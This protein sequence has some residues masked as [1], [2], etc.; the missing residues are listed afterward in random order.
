MLPIEPGT[1]N[2]TFRATRAN[3]WKIDSTQ[4]LYLEERVNVQLGTYDF[5]AERAVVWVERI[6]S[7]KGVITQIAVW[8]PQTSEP[9][10]AAGLGASGS[11][12]L[13]TASTLGDTTL[14]AVLVTPNAPSG[15]STVRSGEQRM[16]EY[17]RGLAERPPLLSLLPDVRRPPPPPPPEPLVVG[18][19]VL[20]KPVAKP[21]GVV[22]VPPGTV[23]LADTPA[24]GVQPPTS[25]EAPTSVAAETRAPIIAPKSLVAFVA[26]K[27]QI[28]TKADTVTLT[29]GVTLDVLPRSP[30]SN[31]RMMQM[32]AERAV[33]FLKPGTTEGLKGVAGEQLTAESVLGVYLEGDISVTDFDYTVRAKRAYYD[34]AK[35]RA[36]LVEGVLR[37]IDRS[38]LPLV[39][40]AAEL[41]QYSQDQWRGEKLVVSTSEFF[42]PHLSVGVERATI[43]R[44]LNDEGK[45]ESYVQGEDVTFRASRTPFFWLPGFEGTGKDIPLRGIG[46]G[47]AGDYGTRITTRWDLLGLLGAENDRH[48]DMTLYS[49]AWINWGA[50]AGVKGK[51]L[52]FKFDAFGLW[53]F[54]NIERTSAGVNVISPNEFR[55]I[56][57]MQRTFDF[58]SDT[59]LQLQANYVSDESFMQIFRQPEFTTQFQ[60]ETSAY[61]VSSGEHSE[62]SLLLNYPTNNVITNGS[63]LAARPYQVAKY[64]EAAYKRWGDSLFGDTVTWTQEYSAN[65][66]AIRFGK[67]SETTTGILSNTLNLE[68]QVLPSGLTF[69]RDTTIKQLYQGSGYADDTYTRLYTRQEL[70]MPLGSGGVHFT[71]FTS[72]A[73]SG[74]VNGNPGT[75]NPAADRLRGLLTFG[76]RASADIMANYDSV[77]MPFL[78]VHRLRH[79][80]TPYANGWY[81]YDSAPEDAYAIFDQD[82]EGATGGAVVQGGVRQRFQTMRGGA[83]NWRSVDWLV[84]DLGAT[85]NDGADTFARDYTSGAHYRQSPFPQFFVWRPELSQ[86]GRTAYGSFKWA[87]SST[88]SFNGNLTY[89]LDSDLPAL[90]QGPFGLSNA[91]RGM[92]G[93]QMQHSPD[94]STFIEYR[95]I[96]NNSPEAIYISDQLLA[97]GINYRVSRTYELGFTPTYDLLENNFRSFNVSVKRELPDFSLVGTFGYDV[98]IG[99]YYGGLAIRIGGIDAPNIRN[100]PFTQ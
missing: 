62:L 14:R 48:T 90:G 32:R 58:T 68:G 76:V 55:G 57:G 94:V 73:I 74:Y 39:A 66:M 71:P 1:W 49:D 22:T 93:A 91:A 50:G 96:N 47:F 87:A 21:D 30:A 89:M 60:K 34:F 41:R 86:W 75:Y 64:P 12:L 51:L 28:D 95:S 35:E 72:A 70:A 67:G 100:L 23:P 98:V 92:I 3:T 5:Y 52:D 69:D 83:G 43:T 97:G 19:S 84:L 46:V 59:K 33:I 99:E 18:G 15:N 2:A 10:K 65:L 82:V 77:E 26:D 16:E 27:V 8:F 61:L 17:L 54:G 44:T 85:W 56:F 7:S 63:Q 45:G 38:G 80:V 6:P 25:V 11:N 24:P 37:T 13:I 29:S 78:D 53:D 79:I 4:R 36:T 88:L 31:A 9:T 81:G 42:T 40:R 20:P